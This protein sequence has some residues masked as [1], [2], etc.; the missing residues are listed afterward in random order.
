MKKN[1]LTLMILILF[2]PFFYSC[3]KN[4]KQLIKKA[5][6]LAYTYTALQNIVA[7]SITIHKVEKVTAM[8]YAEIVFETMENMEHEYHILHQ[9]ALFNGEVEKAEALQ[10]E[11]DK[12]SAMKEFCFVGITSASFDDEKVILYMVK[13]T[14]FEEDYEENSYFFMTPKFALYDLD[15]FGDNLLKSTISQKD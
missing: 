13:F 11:Q 8:R 7:D 6:E 10:T 1:I 9:T 15:P 4:E 2:I 3:K 14:F 5:E 12:V